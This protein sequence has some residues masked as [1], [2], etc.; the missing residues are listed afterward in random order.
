MDIYDEIL[1]LQI[2][3]VDNTMILITSVQTE[4]DFKKYL[5]ENKPFST[6]F[7]ADTLAFI[8]VTNNHEFMDILMCSCENEQRHIIV[9][10]MEAEGPDYSDWIEK[11][12]VHHGETSSAHVSTAIDI[13]GGI[14]EDDF[15]DEHAIESLVNSALDGDDETDEED[16]VPMATA[17]HGK[18]NEFDYEKDEYT[19]GVSDDEES[20][21]EDDFV[22]EIEKSLNIS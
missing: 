5:L 17:A 15:H 9:S 3:Q 6:N 20:V 4:C 11:Y 14:D 18:Q 10:L 7:I 8:L 22:R 21:D 16:L 2:E 19:W 1:L 13:T 12:T